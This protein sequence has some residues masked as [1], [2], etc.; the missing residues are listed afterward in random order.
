MDD[1]AGASTA[2]SSSWTGAGAP[3]C[4]GS[5]TATRTPASR[6]TAPTSSSCG[7]AAPA[8]RSCTRRAAGSSRRCARRGRPATARL[9]RRRRAASRLDAAPT[10]RRRSRRSRATGSTGTR[11][12]RSSGRSRTPAGSRRWLGAHAVPPE[13]PDGD[14]Y[15]D[16]AL[17]EVL[18]GGGRDRRGGGRLPRARRVRR[19]PGAP[20]PRSLPA[21]RGS[22]FGSTPTSS[23]RRAVVA[24]AVELGA[25]SVD[26]L[27]A[28][29][30]GGVRALAPSDVDR[31]AAPRRRALSSAGPMPPARAL[32]DA[33]AIVALATDFNPG[34]RVLREPPASS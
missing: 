16:F 18:P 27:E 23:P 29:G 26:H 22:R 10:G 4:P 24:L 33:G 6:A 14:A 5:S 8:T 12:S 19:R 28:T 20:L 2:T 15:L 9:A 13:F 11:S 17:A 21:T 32:I 34:E 1:L 3:R 30:P 25:R 31:R 7:P